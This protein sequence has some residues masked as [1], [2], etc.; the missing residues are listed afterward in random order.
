MTLGSK[1]EGTVL[2]VVNAIVASLTVYNA[3]DVST[4]TV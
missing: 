3:V 1:V 4:V 2:S